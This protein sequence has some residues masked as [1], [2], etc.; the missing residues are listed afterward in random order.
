MPRKRFDL[1]FAV[2][3]VGVLL[4]TASPVFAQ[5]A[6]LEILS[7]TNGA[8]VLVDGEEVARTPMIEP[9]FVSAGTHVVRVEKQGF[10]A[11]H[12]EVVF[13]E[14]DEIVLE[15]DLLPFGGI[16]RVVTSEPGAIVLA[17]GEEVG[18]TPFEGEIPVGERVFTVRRDLYEDWTHTQVVLAGEEYLLEADMI[19]LPD[20]GTVTIVTET[21]PFYREW[22]F[23]SGAALVIGGG[24]VAAILL[25]EDDEA[26]PV[27]ILISLP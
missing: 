12:E 20:T 22:W 4:A 19:A 10:L 16:V 21:T 26:A 13:E 25:S 11:F 15:V 2:I 6:T 17:D 9:V 8:T 5:E 7:F 23:W 27:D 3:V 24:I 14:D 1:G 18:V